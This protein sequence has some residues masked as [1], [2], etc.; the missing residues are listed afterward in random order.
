MHGYFEIILVL[1][2]NSDKI[3][4]P[5]YKLQFSQVFRGIAF[6]K[7]DFS[8]VAALATLNYPSRGCTADAKTKNLMNR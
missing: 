4:Q 3:T 1:L 2:A 8:Y 5:N 7:T 6:V